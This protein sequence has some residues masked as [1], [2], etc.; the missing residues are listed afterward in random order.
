LQALIWFLSKLNLFRTVKLI[1]LIWTAFPFTIVFAEKTIPLHVLS[2]NIKG[3]PS[4]FLSSDYKDSRYAEIGRILARENGLDIVLLQEAFSAKTK[5]LIQE[6]KLPHI[7]EGPPMDA[8]FGVNSGLYILSRHPIVET[9]SRAFGPENCLRAD[10]LANKG[11]MLARI[12]IPGIAKP[13]E[14]YNTHLQ[15]GREDNQARIR[16]SKILVELFQ[17]N[18]QK[19]SAVI[20]AGDFNFRPGLKQASYFEFSEATNFSHAGK[21]CLENGCARSKDD[22]WQG[23]WERAVD[24]QF[25]SSGTDIQITP[26]SIERTHQFLPSGQKLSDHPAHEVKYLM[27]ILDAKNR[28]T[29]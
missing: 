23:I 16:Q 9:I 26:T 28:P 8:L 13:L 10:C 22:G 4:L 7:A 12:A 21:Y 3:L 11:V 29:K 2:F 27:K 14:V 20:F 15:A 19:G 1:S 6:S 5:I 24:H 18:H 25:Y 17:E